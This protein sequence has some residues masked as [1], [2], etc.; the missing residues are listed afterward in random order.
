MVIET[1]GDIGCGD[2][3]CGDIGCGDI[4]ASD[5]ETGDTG[6]GGTGIGDIPSSTDAAAPSYAPYDPYATS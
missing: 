6:L 5:I 4:G 1:H 3:G 2:I